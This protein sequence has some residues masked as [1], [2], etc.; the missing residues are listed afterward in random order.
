MKQV[1]AFVGFQIASEFHSVEEIQRLLEL[2]VHRLNKEHDVAMQVEYGMFPP[3]TIL[4]DKLRE[5]I[6]NSDIVIFDISENN[7]N[8]MIEVGFGYGFGKQVFLLKNKDSHAEH[9]KPSDLAAVYIPYAP[10]ELASEATAEE[11]LRGISTFLKETHP[12]DYYFRALW[13]FGEFD[14]VLVVCSELD[15]PDKLQH[16][17]PNEYLYLGKYGDV[18]ALLEVLVT[19]HRL[20]PHAKVKF[21]SAGEAKAIRENFSDNIVLV[22]G[23]DYN[24]IADVFSEHC[25][26]DYL[27]G[28]KEE[29]ISL[30]HKSSGLTYTPKIPPAAPG[31]SIMDYGF[32]LKR[33]NP[34][35]AAKRLIMI[36]GAHTYG[37]FGA[38]KAFSYWDPAKGVAYANCKKVVDTL[39]SDPNFCV[40]FEVKG[41]RTTV[42]P[43]AVD[44]SLLEVIA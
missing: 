35:N 8:V 29:D 38:I 20:Y 43:P 18:D 25:F 16:P 3:G 21:R 13:G 39:G 40:M 27:T 22:G 5:G 2:V 9:K 23:P 7:P 26:F 10:R 32:F 37:V 42:P 41:V 4:W 33:R 19:L 1:R 28:E 17:E 30:Q 44:P 15:E 12:P 34:Y 36:G 31:D 6:S 11:L 14:D 24:E